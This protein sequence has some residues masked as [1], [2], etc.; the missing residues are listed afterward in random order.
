MANQQTDILIVGGG[1]I[2]ATLMLALNGLGYRVLLVESKDPDEQVYPN[3]DARSLALSQASRRILK[4]LGVWDKLNDQVTPIDMI[5]VSQQFHFGMARLQADPGNALG[6]VIEMQYLRRALY[7]TLAKDQIIAPAT[8][9]GL[10]PEQHLATVQTNSGELT[11]EAKLIIA[12]DG[13]D[14][15]VRQMCQLTAKTKYYHQHAL[16]ANVGL[17]KPHQSKAFERFTD[18]GPLAL[19]P[20]NN[21]RMSMVW[22][23]SPKRADQLS[24]LDDSLFLT[25]L[26]KAFGYRLGRF[27]KIGKRFIYPLKQVLMAQQVKWP[28]VFI[29]NA[30]HTLHPVAG[31]GFNLGLR[32]VATLAEC[33]AK[34]GLTE[35]MLDHYAQLRQDDQHLITRFTDGLVHLFASKLPGIGF[36]RNMGLIAMDNSSFFKNLLAHYAQ[37]FGGS[38][39]DLVSE[40]ALDKGRSNESIL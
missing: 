9:T 5:H 34:E 29:G 13:A 33:I 31:Q 27:T 23:M 15:A 2:G 4:M 38:I 10:D 35:S 32:D 21:Q 18:E 37:G 3:F 24:H 28:V 22:A 16:V 26:Q 11:I 39:S 6:Y 36:A 1:L 19:L 25:E 30:A 40:L 20:M 12:A 8:L 17:V 14:S 7:D